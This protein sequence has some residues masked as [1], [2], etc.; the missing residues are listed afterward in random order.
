MSAFTEAYDWR[1]RTIFDRDC[2]KIGSVKDAPAK[3]RVEV[4]DDR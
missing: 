2:D 1:G 3:E 4:D